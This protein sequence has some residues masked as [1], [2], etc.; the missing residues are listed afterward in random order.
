MADFL[1]ESPAPRPRFLLLGWYCVYLLAAH[2]PREQTLARQELV[3][4][5]IFQVTLMK[6]NY[7]TPQSCMLLR[8]H[9]GTRGLSLKEPGSFFSIPPE[10]EPLRNDAWSALICLHF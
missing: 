7:R 10:S 2:L 9:A 4:T 1:D 8:D 6:E 5:Q 3:H